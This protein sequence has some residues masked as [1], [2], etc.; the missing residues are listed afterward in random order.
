MRYIVQNNVNWI[1]NENST[2][3]DPNGTQYPPEFPKTGLLGLSPITE[4][5]AP[6]I[7]NTQ[8]TTDSIQLIDGVYTQVW[9]I[10]D[11]TQA[12]LDA[13]K[14]PRASYSPY[15]F[16]LRL[17]GEERIAIR[18]AAATNP[19]IFDFMDM[20]N[21]A[22]SVFLDDPVTMAGIGYLQQ[23]GI[24]TSERASAVLNTDV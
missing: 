24:L 10:R 4:V 21:T 1:I 2:Y 6:T 12:E 14:P 16:K 8:V 23:Q 11:K 18:N 15:Q 19:I 5:E 17:T 3:I 9:A 13:E 20:L 22:P 7:L